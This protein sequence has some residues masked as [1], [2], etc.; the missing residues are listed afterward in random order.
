MTPIL[1]SHVSL[2]KALAQNLKGATNAIHPSSFSDVHY[3]LYEWQGSVW[4][5]HKSELDDT[6]RPKSL[7][8]IPDANVAGVVYA[9]VEDSPLWRAWPADKPD[10]PGDAPEPAKRG[11]GRPP[12][13]VVPPLL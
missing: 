7:V 2:S 10:G 1:L 3:A 8:R 6:G 11:P 4:V 12:K 13:Q 5:C 9:N